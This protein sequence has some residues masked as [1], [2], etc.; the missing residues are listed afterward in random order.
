VFGFCAEN[1]FFFFFYYTS[2]V[3]VS[4]STS[5]Y[6]EWRLI[7]CQNC[8]DQFVHFEDDVTCVLLV[9]VISTFLVSDEPLTEN[10]RLSTLAHLLGTHYLTIYETLFSACQFFDQK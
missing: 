7:I 9:A 1:N 2:V 5:V 4:L 8:A 3:G 6:T 10:G